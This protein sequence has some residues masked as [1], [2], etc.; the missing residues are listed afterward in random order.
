MLSFWLNYTPWKGTALEPL[1]ML[2][3]LIALKISPNSVATLSFTFPAHAYYRWVAEPCTVPPFYQPLWPSKPPAR[4][5]LQGWQRT[6][7]QEV[8]LPPSICRTATGSGALLLE[9]PDLVPCCMIPQ[10]N[11]NTYLFCSWVVLIRNL[12]REQVQ[13]GTT[14][15][16][17]RDHINPRDPPNK[18]SPQ[19][20]LLFDPDM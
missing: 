9:C 17:P 13:K 18:N 12:G 14:G 1:G 20:P 2:R 19:I 11:R 4:E 16:G 10:V 15:R 6:K 8:P 5:P 3:E 7:W